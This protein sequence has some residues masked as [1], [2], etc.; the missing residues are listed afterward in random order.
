MVPKGHH[1]LKTHMGTGGGAS[2]G[3][4]TDVRRLFL[5]KFF[6]QVHLQGGTDTPLCL[7]HS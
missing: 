5:V 1:L 3:A 7:H 6:P 2:T 4:S